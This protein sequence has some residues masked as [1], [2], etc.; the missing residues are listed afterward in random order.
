MA[1]NSAN[2]SGSGQVFC[3]ADPSGLG[4]AACPADST[5]FSFFSCNARCCR[6]VVSQVTASRV[7]SASDSCLPSDQR[8]VP[9]T[10]DSSPVM[11]TTPAGWLV[12]QDRF[13]QPGQFQTKATGGARHG[14]VE[15]MEY[16][17][18]SRDVD[19]RQ[20]NN[21][22]GWSSVFKALCGCGGRA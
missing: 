3:Q 9:R 21:P 20:Q 22:Y 6:R 8:S 17:P 4:S 18:P 1:L 5:V 7:F 16:A 2:A 10:N 11:S 13:N 15:A 19:D 14:A 12:H